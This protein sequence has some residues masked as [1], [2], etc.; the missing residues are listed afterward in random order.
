MYPYPA[1][2][3]LAIPDIKTVL[4]AKTTFQMK[5]TTVKM[6]DDFFLS[7]LQLSTSKNY[8]HGAIR[9][10]K[11]GV[12]ISISCN[13]EFHTIPI[14]FNSATFA[15]MST[16]DILELQ[17]GDQVSLNFPCKYHILER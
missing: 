1:R 13:G 17:L 2:L 14:N 5:K 10:L 12:S 7:I 16:N 3:P 6:I 9:L 4:F 8:P 15:T 11:N